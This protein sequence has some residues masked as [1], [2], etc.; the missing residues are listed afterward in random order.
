MITVPGPVTSGFEIGT[1]T[2]SIESDNRLIVPITNT[3]N[4]LVK[5]T[6]TLTVTTPEGNTI[7]TAPIAMGS[8]YGGLSSTIMLGLPAQMQPGPYLVSLSLSDEETGANDA[9]DAI[10]VELPARE[11]A[12]PAFTLDP[13]SVT[14]SG[15]PIQYADVT[16]TITNADR[17]IP[18]ATVTLKVSR[19]GQPV[20]D[21]VL[22]QNQA[23]VNGENVI[24][25]RY[26]PAGGWVSG[27]WTFQVVVS[28]V[29]GSGT[30]TELIAVDV[31]ASIVI[32]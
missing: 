26:I 6:G 27:T 28:E 22:A 23:L 5:P 10:S 32:P 17:V 16:A 4:I 14:A 24:S 30:S 12:P 18:T 7:I 20:E 1:P 31:P 9:M 29:D 25:Q 2:F 13:V 3:G 19:D 11:T 15:E 21:Y 8:I